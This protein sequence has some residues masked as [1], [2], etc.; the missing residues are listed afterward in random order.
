MK[1]ICPGDSESP[2]L[3]ESPVSVTLHHA[4]LRY[5]LMGLRLMTQPFSPVFAHAVT[6]QEI[7]EIPMYH[8][9]WLK[10]K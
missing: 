6:H 9:V 7:T 1:T 8:R 3:E 2:P 4:A 5:I 10:S